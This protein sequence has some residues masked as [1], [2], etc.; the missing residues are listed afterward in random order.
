MVTPESGHSEPGFGMS[1]NRLLADVVACTAN[2]EA[3]AIWT[4]ANPVAEWRMG[5]KKIKIKKFLVGR[6][7]GL[8]LLIITRTGNRLRQNVER[9]NR[10][11]S[12]WLNVAFPPQAP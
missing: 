3:K 12:F 1:E 2:D 11:A 10:R 5:D 7:Q 8:P 4:T 9:R 6:A